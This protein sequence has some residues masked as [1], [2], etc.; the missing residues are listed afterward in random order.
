MS[1]TR[2]AAS[3]RQGPVAWGHVPA[4]DGIRGLAV[5]AVLLFHGGVSWAK[6]GFLGVDTFFVLSGLLITSLLLDEVTTTDRV[7][8]RRFWARR[9]RRLV[10]ALLLLLAATALF[11]ATVAAAGSLES[12]RKDAFAAL[13]YVSNWRF[14]LA[15]AD[16][17]E[18]T[19]TPSVL[20]HTWSLAIE[21]QFYVVWP[22]VLAA[23][24]RARASTRLA[25]VAGIAGVGV[26]VSALTMALLHEPGQDP[27][28]AYYGTDSRVH[29]VLVGAVLAVVVAT[30]RRRRATLTGGAAIALGGAA[31]VGSAVVLV[32]IATVAGEETALFRGGFLLVALCV[33][34]LL[35][36]VVLVP[37]GWA[38]RLLS[39]APLRVVG[40]VSYGAYLWHWPIYLT[41]TAQRT[42]LTGPGLLAAR[43]AVTAAAA[44]VSY[45]L[46][47]QPIRRG[48]LP[49]WH[50]GT[51][52]A[53]AAIAVTGLVLVAT[54]PPATSA[55]AA[56]APLPTEGGLPKPKRPARPLGQPAK[57][58]VVGDSVAKTLADRFS[59]R[60]ARTY[61]LA[62]TNRGVL[63]C[64]VVRG[65][66]F[67]YFGQ[68][69]SDPPPCAT[70]PERW[71]GHVQQ[72]DPDVVLM[73]VGRW[74]VM[75]RTL[76][77]RWTNVGRPD[78]DRLLETELERAVSVLTARRAVLAIATAPYFL[79][80]ERPDGGRWPEDDPARVDRFNAVLR[81]VAAR[82]R[83]TVHVL[84]LNERTSVGG[85]Y[86]PIVAGVSMRFDG[87]HFSPQGAAW[88]APW[89]LESLRQLAPG[90]SGKPGPTTTTAPTVP[91]STTSM[92][93]VPST[94]RTT[95][96]PSTTSTTEA[97]T[98]TTTERPVTTTT[99]PI[100]IVP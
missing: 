9:A 44:A 68:V 65:S 90:Q 2:P 84:D 4:L 34:A 59:A 1:A 57:V 25:W 37:D 100:D 13:L 97:P 18:A 76:R 22:L 49:G 78:F 66:P 7:D 63:G 64:G 26:V 71:A 79:R 91:R 92:V 52:A 21:E 82:H 14:I 23:V 81:R 96:P 16:Y 27:S 6:G 32:A 67:R 15:G 77:G 72:D 20:R 60:Q 40:L 5:I 93:P 19:A 95:R 42:G 53:A 61:D 33:A 35:A 45:V 73:I 55:V 62:I 30:I 80:G 74:E 46:V 47:E 86:T 43:L 70:W 85:V 94:T 56:A 24:A 41:M 89:I 11:A 69:R 58:L 98:T 29:V 87:V 48:A 17:F 51:A 75:D 28:R 88:L 8:L 38:A 36:D 99:S 10:P 3:E 50:A 54:L 31:L 39:W 12:L 83:D